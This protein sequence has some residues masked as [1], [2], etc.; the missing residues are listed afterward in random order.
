MKR[1]RRVTR[2]VEETPVPCSLSNL[3]KVGDC[4][5][6]MLPPGK[7]SLPSAA[8]GVQQQQQQQQSASAAQVQQQLPPALSWLKIC[9]GR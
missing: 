4:D 7:E 9:F 5:E 1:R 8:P 3:R 6:P 2:M